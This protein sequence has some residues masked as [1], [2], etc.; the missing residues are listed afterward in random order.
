MLGRCRAIFVAFAL[1]LVVGAGGASSARAESGGDLPIYTGFEFPVIE[2]AAD[3][4]DYSW[5]V[6]LRNGQ[7]LRSISPTEAEVDYASGH[8][9]YEIDAEKAS[10]ANGT[11]VPTTLEV[12]E[13]D[14]ITF[15]VHHREAAYRYPVV[16]GEGWSGGWREPTIIKGPP[17]ETEIRE[18]EEARRR[19]EE[20]ERAAAVSATT[21]PSPS[22]ICTVPALHDLSLAAAKSR[23]RGAHCGVGQVHLGAGATAGKG[24][25][26]RQFRDAGTE[27]AAGTPVAVKLGVR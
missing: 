18:M 22:V 17:D 9:A 19:A 10:D 6:E 3:P 12:T 4:E 15:V 27:L 13:G 2:S 7:T 11:A 20:A 5:R 21:A 1:A 8:L 25:V 14:V 26:V 16:E 24:K 23:L